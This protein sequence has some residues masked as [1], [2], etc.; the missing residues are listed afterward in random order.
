[1]NVEHIM[2]LWIIALFANIALFAVSIALKTTWQKGWFIVVTVGTLIPLFSIPI[3]V[4][5][6]AICIAESELVEWIAKKWKPLIDWKGE[7]LIGDKR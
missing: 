6:L 3:S 4:C 5:L 2:L 1:M 7:P